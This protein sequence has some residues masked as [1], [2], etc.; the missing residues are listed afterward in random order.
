MLGE[1]L[2]VVSP[3]PALP[4]PCA[5]HCHPPPWWQADLSPEDGELLSPPRL[6]GEGAASPVTSRRLPQ[7]HVP[8]TEPAL[9]TA[10]HCVSEDTRALLAATRQAQCRPR[11]RTGECED[12]C[13]AQ[14]PRR[15]GQPGR[16]G[17]M[18]SIRSPPPRSSQ[19]QA[20]L[21]THG[22]TAASLGP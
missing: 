20:G 12:G 22:A 15:P 19:S 14:G 10:Q 13:Q 4:R 9:H 16:W 18:V 21:G 5:A 17:D 7:R 11:G 3:W 8:P 2:C 6:P 1:V